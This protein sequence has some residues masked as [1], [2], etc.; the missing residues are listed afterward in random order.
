MAA[1]AAMHELARQPVSHGSPLKKL[2]LLRAVFAS[3]MSVDW[4]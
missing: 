4:S 2:F 1:E 3:G